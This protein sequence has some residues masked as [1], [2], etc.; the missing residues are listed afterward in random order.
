VSERALSL[1]RRV[2]GR[3]KRAR[4]Q[5][6]IP[7]ALLE[8]ASAGVTPLSGRDVSAQTRL[9]I[10]IVI[11]SFRRGSGGHATIAHLAT[12]L[13]ARG[14]T[15]SLWLED[16][17]RLHAPTASTVVAQQFAEYF[18]VGRIELQTSFT[19]WAGADVVLA[20]GWET[21]PRVLRLPGAAGRAY[22][23]QDHEPEFYGTSAESLLAAETYRAGLHCI[24]A[25]PWL[26]QLLHTRYGADVSH[27]DL[28]V[29]HGTYQP[30][31]GPRHARQVLFYART[32][33]SRRAVPLGLLA[34]H[35]L[36]R[37]RPDVEIALFGSQSL[38]YAPFPHADL[39]VLAPSELASLYGRATVGMVFSLTNPSLIGLEMMTCGLPCVELGSEPMRSVFTPGGPL[40]LAQPAPLQICST[41]AALLDDE[42]LR[43]EL[44]RGGVAF[45]QG[46]TWSRAGEQL[47]RGLR[48][49]LARPR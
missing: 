44:S 29:D 47:E 6:V 28:A 48:S 22:L 38:P 30:G 25:S 40:V 20:T 14:H 36:S 19:D 3:D 11:P 31:A 23:V 34:L 8:L 16:F 1:A 27:F 41:I 26:A 10:A 42:A 43:A 45:M 21:V 13:A 4:E 39:G 5:P 15:I 33:T 46:R 18:S 7:E 9:H 37:Q 35:E 2:A 12:A 32:A 17:Q 49:S 24:A